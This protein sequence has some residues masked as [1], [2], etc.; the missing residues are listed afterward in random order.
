MVFILNDEY[1]DTVPF[2]PKNISVEEA[3]YISSHGIMRKLQKVDVVDNSEGLL[4]LHLICSLIISYC[5][6]RM[7]FTFYDGRKWA[8]KIK[9]PCKF[10][11]IDNLAYTGCSPKSRLN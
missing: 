1:G 5:Y 10:H 7:C 11:I 8:L 6:E 9:R 3:A 4:F 2:R